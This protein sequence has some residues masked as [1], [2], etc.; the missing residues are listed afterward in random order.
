MASFYEDPPT[1][2]K[3]LQEKRTCKT[4]LRGIVHAC[5]RRVWLDGSEEPSHGASEEERSQ[6]LHKEGIGERLLSLNVKP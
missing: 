3:D 5:G 1:E 6:T 2:E 4:P